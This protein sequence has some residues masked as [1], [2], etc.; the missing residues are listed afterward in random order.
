MFKQVLWE[1]SNQQNKDKGFTLRKLIFFIIIVGSFDF[2]FTSCAI[3]ANTEP[4]T[5]IPPPVAVPKNECSSAKC[6]SKKLE[7]IDKSLSLLKAHQD[8]KLKP[9]YENYSSEYNGYYQQLQSIFKAPN[10]IN[11]H[12]QLLRRCKDS[13]YIETCNLLERTAI[14]NNSIKWLDGKIK[15]IKVQIAELEQQKWKLNKKIELKDVASVEE[16]TK[17]NQLITSTQVMLE[18]SLKPPEAQDIG[19]IQ[20]EIFDQISSNNSGGSL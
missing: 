4:N 6:L 7:E 5:D 9:L 8:D 16:Y 3:Q 19:K 13:E 10:S 18:E 2:L 20:Q 14:L 11:S 1:K 15:N 12:E 17:I